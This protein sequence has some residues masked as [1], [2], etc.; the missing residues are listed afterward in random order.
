MPE[1]AVS[2]EYLEMCQKWEDQ[3]EGAYEFPIVSREVAQAVYEDE[4]QIPDALCTY[5][6]I[7]DMVAREPVD[8]S[9]TTVIVR[10]VRTE[11]VQQFFEPDQSR[12]DVCK[13]ADDLGHTYQ[14]FMTANQPDMN[15]GIAKCLTIHPEQPL[16]LQL[17]LPPTDLTARKVIDTKDISSE[18]GDGNL[19]HRFQEA[20]EN[21]RWFFVRYYKGL[22]GAQEA[23]RGTSGENRVE[24]QK[25]LDETRNTRPYIALGVLRYFPSKSFAETHPMA[26]AP[27]DAQ[28]QRQEQTL[29]DRQVEC[30]WQ[31]QTLVKQ[32]EKMSS[33]PFADRR[34]K[35]AAVADIPEVCFKRWR[36]TLF[37]SGHW[38]VGSN[39]M[40]LALPNFSNELKYADFSQFMTSKELAVFGTY[41]NWNKPETL[42]G[43]GGWQSIW[44][45]SGQDS[46]PMQDFRKWLQDCH[47]NFDEDLRFE[48]SFA[49]HPDLRSQ[50][51]QE[52]QVE[53]CCWHK[54]ILSGQKELSTGDMFSFKHKQHKKNVYAEA[55]LFCRDPTA[56]ESAGTVYFQQLPKNFYPE[57][58]SEPLASLVVSKDGLTLLEYEPKKKQA[59]KNAVARELEMKRPHKFVIST[60]RSGQQHEVAEGE[61]VETESNVEQ[62]FYVDIVNRYN[63]S[64]AAISGGKIGDVKM[65]AR[66]VADGPFDSRDEAQNSAR[67]SNLNPE[68]SDPPTKPMALN[69]P[70]GAFKRYQK[71]GFY[72]IDFEC[73]LDTPEVKANIAA[74]RTLPPMAF[75]EFNNHRR[76]ILE[77]KGSK[78][79]QFWFVEGFEFEDG[80]MFNGGIRIG[81]ATQEEIELVL[82]DKHEN[83]IPAT[84]DHLRGLKVT[85][86]A[87]Q[88]GV[89]DSLTL[90]QRLDKSSGLKLTKDGTLLL[91]LGWTWPTGAAWNR[92][93]SKPG[94]AAKFAVTLKSE[95]RRPTGV[96]SLSNLKF[97]QDCRLELW[98]RAPTELRVNMSEVTIGD[99]EPPISVAFMDENGN[100]SGAI[101]QENRNV[102][103]VLKLGAKTFK[104]CKPTAPENV[105]EAVANGWNRY[106]TNR[107]F[108]G[109]FRGKS[110]C[111]AQLTATCASLD[112]QTS[113]IV[114]IWQPQMP[115]AA[116]VLCGPEAESTT[117]SADRSSLENLRIKLENS[118]GNNVEW[119][120]QSPIKVSWN[121]HDIPG[122]TAN[123]AGHLPPLDLSNASSVHESPY[124][125]EGLAKFRGTDGSVIEIDLRFEVNVIAGSAVRWTVELH[126]QVIQVNEPGQL[127][128]AISVL[129]VDANGNQGADPDSVSP[130][131]ELVESSGLLELTA[132]GCKETLRAAAVKKFLPKRNICL[133]GLIDPQNPYVDLRVSDP[134][135]SL[136]PHEFRLKLQPGEATELRLA[137]SI[138]TQQ[139]DQYNAKVPAVWALKDLE[140]MLVDMGGNSVHAADVVLN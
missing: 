93:L 127:E 111:E 47:Q 74:G 63:K 71:A 112:L 11:L 45:R 43:S 26:G 64:L 105:Q 104:M 79:H 57:L 3:G 16:R 137:H 96:E 7:K 77:V 90:E 113:V 50:L 123:Y 140:A 31:G 106:Y 126:K 100:E 73:V 34:V 33:L 130:I 66:L 2:L 44:N 23:L 108:L 8:G 65:Q 1:R 15:A 136:E 51:R 119:G 124:T 17:R 29:P 49:P 35:R 10:G 40:E 132:G 121:G 38:D 131:I 42:G 102:D 84:P 20:G 110:S 80:G 94:S 82:Q 81:S 122:V 4:P 52:D 28:E 59:C 134:E 32:T 24:A 125:Y 118:L 58:L 60:G 12:K 76:E 92:P 48:N 88:L 6:S 109:A 19:E 129:P 62:F 128:S 95:I 25:T 55:V 83:E 56:D 37:C 103:V 116:V 69:D 99:E 120:D 101:G 85:A 46:Q 67:N 39:K 53:G 30:R 72:A 75:E 22:A 68:G 117:V 27:L 70:R 18:F 87:R 13:L 14:Y 86:T 114:T 9:F 139:E 97:P 138:L 36:C 78:V 98:P 135:S 91:K 89:K 21:E 133:N 61:G 41:V 107:G 54:V 115:V 5:D